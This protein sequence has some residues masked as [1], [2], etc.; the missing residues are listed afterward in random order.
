MDLPGVAVHR[1]RDDP[2]AA[3]PVLRALAPL[4]R[5]AAGDWLVSGHPDLGGRSPCSALR[6]GVEPHRVAALAAADE[7]NT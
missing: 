1:R 5:S 3:I 2:P 7:A 6:D 4:D